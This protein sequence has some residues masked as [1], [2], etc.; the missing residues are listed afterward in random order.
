MD[1][2]V[3]QDVLGGDHETPNAYICADDCIVARYLLGGG[4]YSAPRF[5][6]HD[7]A[8]VIELQPANVAVVQL[9]SQ[10]PLHHSG[11]R[12]IEG[13]DRIALC[14]DGYPLGAADGAANGAVRAERLRSSHGV[15]EVS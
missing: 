8:V 4:A 7:L 9:C 2:S 3:Q 12:L 5:P 1:L 15:K 6:R 11:R 13:I 14:P 10:E